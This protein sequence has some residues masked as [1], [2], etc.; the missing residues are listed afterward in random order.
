MCLQLNSRLFCQI[1]PS[2]SLSFP[3]KWD[4]HSPRGSVYET[5]NHSWSPPDSL[6]PFNQIFN[7][8]TFFLKLS[9]EPVSPLPPHCSYSHPNPW[10]TSKASS[11]TD[12]PAFSLVLLQSALLQPLC[13]SQNA[14][15]TISLLYLKSFKRFLIILEQSPKLH[16]DWQ[17]LAFLFH[18]L[19]WS[20][21]PG[22]LPSPWLGQLF[23]T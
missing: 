14:R 6:S 15:L 1:C 3:S 17:G 21:H 11:L 12:L 18:S 9:F 2:S 7:S 16:H 13:M 22:L 20:C 19:L 8:H 5:K 10:T 23:W 4:Y